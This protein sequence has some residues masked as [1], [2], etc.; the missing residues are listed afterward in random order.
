MEIGKGDWSHDK[1]PWPSREVE[2]SMLFL[3]RSVK[4]QGQI[5]GDIFLGRISCRIQPKGAT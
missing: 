2:M 3:G 1:F 5:V 4:G